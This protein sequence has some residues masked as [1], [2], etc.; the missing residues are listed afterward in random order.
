M[1]FF[2]RP[3]E[4]RTEFASDTKEQDALNANLRVELWPS[5]LKGSHYL[6]QM[7]E[8]KLRLHFAT[9]EAAVCLFPPH[10]QNTGYCA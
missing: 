5:P 9:S 7:A 1:V 10:Y 6:R 4:G 3:P 8:G 2:C